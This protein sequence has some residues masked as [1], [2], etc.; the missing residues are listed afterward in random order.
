MT[1]FQNASKHTIFHRGDKSVN[2]VGTLGELTDIKPGMAVKSARV[3]VAGT[4]YIDNAVVKVAS[5]DAD[6]EIELAVAVEYSPT[7][8]DAETGV[9][10]AVATA[11]SGLRSN[12][13]V[14]FKNPQ[15]GDVFFGLV[16]S[17]HAAFNA[18]AQFQF[19]DADAGYFE[20]GTTSVTGKIKVL[21]GRASALT[22]D[23]LILMK[24]VS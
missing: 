13:P 21:E 16:K 14:I 4:D 11:A 15:V 22:A 19:D 3:Q 2:D 12:P 5:A 1:D 7:G 6:T 8:M 24:R 10:E 18:Q 23:E 20:A 9:Y 17:G